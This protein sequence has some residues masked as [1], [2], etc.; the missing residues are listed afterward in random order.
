VTATIGSQTLIEATITRP[1]SGAWEATARGNGAPLAGAVTLT[2]AGTTWAA[3]VREAVQDGGSVRY[4]LIAGKANG[5]RAPV[6]ARSYRAVTVQTI[7]DDLARESGELLSSTIAAELLARPVPSYHRQAGRVLFA[8]DDLAD[9]LGVTWR[10]LEDGTLWLGTDAWTASATAGVVQSTQGDAATVQVEAPTIAPGTVWQGR[11]VEACEHWLERN[12]LRTSIW[13]ADPARLMRAAGER[14]ARTRYA[15]LYPAQVVSQDPADGSLELLIDHPDLR[16]TGLAGVALWTGCDGLSVD[17]E[18]GDQVLVG[19]LD[20][21]PARPFAMLSPTGG[22]AKR[23]RIKAGTEITIDGPVVKVGTGAQFVALS[24]LVKTEIG[25]LRSWCAS[26]THAVST[27]GTASAQTGTA[28]AAASAPP[29]VGDV[30][31][32]NLKA[33]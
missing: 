6:E 4:D 20:G 22:T 29:T 19:F 12:G 10:A 15:R 23:V 16:G 3:C 26:H 9:C 28:A 2:I 17:L 18:A 11:R 31:S 30:A 27:T 13:S 33:D 21:S 25:A 24:N 14:N 1:M 5:W 32:S 7:L 8:L